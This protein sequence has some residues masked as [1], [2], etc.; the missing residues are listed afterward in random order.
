M[1]DDDTAL[2]GPRIGDAA[3]QGQY[4]AS[5]AGVPVLATLEDQLER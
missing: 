3:I 1:G 5:Q 4:V 2:K